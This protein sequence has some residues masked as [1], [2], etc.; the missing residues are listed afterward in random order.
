M[1]IVVLGTALSGAALSPSTNLFGASPTV[2]VVILWVCG[3][4]GNR[5]DCTR[6]EVHA[7]VEPREAA[8]AQAASKGTSVCRFETTTVAALRRQLP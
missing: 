1:V 4:G 5:V 2:A 3:V 6:A 8:P 7:R